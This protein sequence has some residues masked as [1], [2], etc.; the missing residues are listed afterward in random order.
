MVMPIQFD[1]S[2]AQYYLDCIRDGKAIEPNEEGWNRYQ[3][4]QL[5]G[6]LF[7]GLLTHGPAQATK[8]QL[9]EMSQ[10]HQEATE[11]TLFED[12][13]AGI[14]FSANLHMLVEDGEYDQHY[15]EQVKLLVTQDEHGKR[16]QVVEGLRAMEK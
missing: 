6:A 12:I 5:A 15:R 8:S 16:V 10:E 3:M 9:A 11:A 7:F 13:H 4:L 14:E 2:R 1:K